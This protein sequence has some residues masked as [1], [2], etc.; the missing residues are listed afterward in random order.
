MCGIAGY[1]QRDSS[2]S[3]DALERMMGRLVHRGPDDS[4]TW[5]GDSGPWKIRLGHRRLS[6]IDLE[7]GRQPMENEDGGVRIVFNGEIYNFAALREELLRRGHRF[8][9]RSDTE[10]IIHHYEERGFEGIRDLDGMFAFAL[11]DRGRGRLVLARDR[12]G[13]KPLYYASL[14]DGG[15]AFASELT[16][17]LRHEGVARGISREALASYFFCDYVSAP[18]SMIS[19]VRKLEPGHALIWESGRVEEPR[20]FWRLEQ[21]RARDR[22]SCGDHAGLATELLRTL[23]ES[24]RSQLVSDVPIGV[25]LSGGIDS[26]LVAALAQEESRTR[27]RTFSIAFEDPTFDESSYARLVARSIGSEH[28]EET[29]SEGI[30]VETL[31][32]ALAAL[33]EP[34]A[35]PSIIPTYLLSRLASRH[36]KV[37]LGG[38]GGDELWGGYPTYRAYQL[39]SLYG[40]IP[41]AVRDSLIAPIVAG[42]PVDDRYQS[43]EWKAKRFIGR[44]DDD[45]LARHLR[46]MSATD[47][48]EILEAFPDASPERIHP[49]ERA[50]HPAFGG[51]LNSLLALDFQTYLPGSVLTKVDRASMA[52]GLE[53]RPP[54]LGNDFIDF[55]FSLPSSLKLSGGKGKRL[56]K[57]AARG[58]VPDEVIDRPKKGFGIPLARWLRGPIRPLIETA[59]RESPLWDSSAIS[60]DRFR[61]WASEHQDRARDHSKTLW[62]LVV[63]DQWMKRENIHVER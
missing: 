47:L 20:P 52:H 61:S 4:G 19:G 56:L 53:V 38:D 23:R 22:E 25:F 59:L 49:L 29:L 33:D 28:V 45:P 35:D 18:L 37:A 2:E 13:I 26:S 10:A 12:A 30:L 5:G 48:P 42:L 58:I 41:G 50:R 32:Q 40:R 21:V 27:L 46:W 54:M 1:I 14:P 8:A 36:V 7:A 55:A 24:V 34:M 62:A 43:F 63:L 31:P 15:I 57:Q 39:A 16:A 11:W 51:D 9:T 3:V 6:I 44:W 60:R 17:L